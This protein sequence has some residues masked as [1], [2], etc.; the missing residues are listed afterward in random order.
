MWIEPRILI[1]L[2][3]WDINILLMKKT[4]KKLKEEWSMKNN[5]I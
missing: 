1:I 2:C 4:I 5:D 3:Y